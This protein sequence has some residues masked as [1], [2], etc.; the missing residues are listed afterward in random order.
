M[1]RVPDDVGRGG[2]SGVRA[3]RLGPTP[4]A[5]PLVLALPRGGVPVAYEVAIALHAPLD[6]FVARKVGAPGH[7][8]LGIGAIAEGS[9]ELIVTQTAR[10][11]GLTSRQ[12]AVLAARE[13]TELDR[14]VEHYRGGAPLPSPAA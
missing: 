9:D 14:R 13:R 11:L 8:E 10:A 2:A 4:F 3:A 1:P 7:E 5:D 12:L 6:V